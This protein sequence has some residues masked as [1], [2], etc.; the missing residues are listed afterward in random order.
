[1]FLGPDLGLTCCW[2]L[3]YGYGCIDMFYVLT[4]GMELVWCGQFG[5]I[6]LYLIF[7]DFVGISSFHVFS[8]RFRS[9]WGV[10]V[11]D[12]VATACARAL[13]LARYTP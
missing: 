10:H 1:M 5:L 11:G 9:E 4:G 2:S 3:I 12:S 13:F 6:S 8:S 7:P